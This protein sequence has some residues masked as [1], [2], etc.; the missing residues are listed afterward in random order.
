MSFD[1]KSRRLLSQ[2]A[3]LTLFMKPDARAVAQSY[4]SL[5]MQLTASSSQF[6][7]GQ[8]L[9]SCSR[10]PIDNR[11]CTR[12][13]SSWTM[14]C[15]SL[16]EQSNEY[17]C[18]SECVRSVGGHVF[19]GSSNRLFYYVNAD[20]TTESAPC[21]PITSTL[22]QSHSFFTLTKV[23]SEFNQIARQLLPLSCYLLFHFVDSTWL[24]YLLLQYCKLI[25]L[26][27]KQC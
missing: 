22:F 5:G 12:A 18:V 10:K 26:C 25:K 16:E 13:S 2:S 23:T 19:L 8:V 11:N 7:L 27:S 17:E 6:P 9:S 24:L 1:V 21:G 20:A 4:V 14:K 3:T 15:D